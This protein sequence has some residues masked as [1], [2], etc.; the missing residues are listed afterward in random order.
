VARRQRSSCS[1]GHKPIGMKKL[2]NF[3]NFKLL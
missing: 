2:E 3:F 1:G